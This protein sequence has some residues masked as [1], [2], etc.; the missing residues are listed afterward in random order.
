MGGIWEAAVKFTK[1]LLHRIISDRVLTYEEFN[2]VL[3][4]IEATLNSRP[5]GAMSS[6]PSDFKTLTAGHFLT[7]GPL[8]TLPS[9]EELTNSTVSVSPRNRWSLIQQIH[10][11]FW[12]RWNKEYL[13]TLQERLKWDQQNVNLQE[14]DLVIVKEPSPH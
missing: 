7:M 9:P 10:Q 2:T 12:L 4:Q 3:H 6:D 11:H 5:L 1:T 8:V 13:H 14:N